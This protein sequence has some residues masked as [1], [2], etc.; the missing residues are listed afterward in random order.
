MRQKLLSN[1]CDKR[2][3]KDTLYEKKRRKCTNNLIVGLFIIGK[4]DSKIHA[5]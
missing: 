1:A 5:L 2:I 3:K 4:I